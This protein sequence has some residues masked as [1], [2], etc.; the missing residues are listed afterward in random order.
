MK[1]HREE[2]N[3]EKMA[4]AFG[5]T[6]SGYYDF[7]KR[8]ESPRSK[9]KKRLK[10]KIR[11]IH[12]LSRETYGSP[13]IHAVMKSQGES[14]SRK[15]IAKWMHEEKIQ[16]KMRKRWTR[17]T[18]V[19]EK[20]QISANLL[21]QNF[22]TDAPNKVWVSD[23]T[24]VPTQEGWLYVAMVMDLFSRRIVGLSMG[25]RL[26][27]DLVTKALKQALFHRGVEKGILHHSDRGCQYTSSDFKELTKRHGIQLSMSS[28]GNCYDN[29]VAESFF[30][31]L[32]TEHTHFCN[33]RTREE[34]INSPEFDT[35]F[36]SIK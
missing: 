15:R 16:A 26:Q 34:A 7:L 35:C 29:A 2:F 17:T 32:K 1:A 28:T 9:E 13:R 14:C 30:H 22:L 4:K 36:A 27:T 10:D 25:N 3:I 11:N 18:R 19:D 12:K 21:N 24:Y 20:A 23:I 33:Y 6:R 31:T 8:K 5:V